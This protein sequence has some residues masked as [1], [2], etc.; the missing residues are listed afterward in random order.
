[1][2]KLLV[3]AP[4]Y[5]SV[6]HSVLQH[7]V[8]PPGQAM[9]CRSAQQGFVDGLFRTSMLTHLE[10][11]YRIVTMD[12]HSTTD[13]TWGSRNPWEYEQKFTMYV[14]FRVNITPRREPSDDPSFNPP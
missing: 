13:V 2:A 9:P 3:P 8:N 7:Y 14:L 5:L 1:M 10:I 6:Q 11:L 12:L 4:K